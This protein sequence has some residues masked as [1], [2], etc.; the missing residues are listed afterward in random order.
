MT[1]PLNNLR[2]AGTRVGLLLIPEDSMARKRSNQRGRIVPRGDRF[3]LRYT[4]RDPESPSG[5]RD[6]REFLPVGTT[7]QQAE[8]IRV[9]RMVHI[10]KLNNSLVIQPA[11]SLETFTQ[12][13]WV[14][15]QKERNLSEST[16]Y[17]YDSMLRN[18]VL[19]S[20]GRVRLDR[21]SPQHLTR[22]MKAAREKPYSSK[23]RLNLYSMLKILF[24]VAKDYDLITASPV[25]A[26]VHRPVHE[27]T[28]KRSFTPDE[29]RALTRHIPDEKHRLL[30]YVGGVL[31]LRLGEVIALQWRDRKNGGLRIERSLWRGRLKKPKTRASMKFMPLPQVLNEWLDR[32]QEQ[33]EGK[34]EQFIFRRPDGRP[35]D[36]DALRRRV[37]YPVLDALEIERRPRAAGFHALRHSAGSLVYLASRDLEQVKRYMRHS[38]IGTTSDVYL[39]DIGGAVAEEAVGTMTKVYFEI[40][41]VQ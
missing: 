28:E 6:C 3:T 24:D 41:G 31:G 21:I 17:S 33:T 2:P 12:T 25:R 32:Y 1:N 10:N 23:Y 35:L 11:M 7:I 40:E 26:K 34:G 29:L 19:P 13:L 15:Y 18:L 8:A 9:E 39:H 27:R 37:L 30:F 14:E 36:P 22:L 20:L 38:R 4:I 5:W 16:V